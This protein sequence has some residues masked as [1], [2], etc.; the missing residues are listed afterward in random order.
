MNS[1][2]VGRPLKETTLV[3]DGKSVIF[4]LD[5]SDLNILIQLEKQYKFSRSEVLRILIRKSSKGV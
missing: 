4:W 1:N 5:K 3:K 2:Y